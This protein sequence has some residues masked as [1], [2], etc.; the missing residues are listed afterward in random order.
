MS[1]L[2]RS[3]AVCAA[4][5]LCLP[6]PASAQVAYGTITDSAGRA[7][8]SAEV[9]FISPDGQTSVA[10]QRLRGST[11]F[12][13]SA[14]PP[15][16]RYISYS[17]AACAQ[18]YAS[19]VVTAPFGR[20]DSLDVAF[21]LGHTTSNTGGPLPD[22]A[23]AWRRDPKVNPDIKPGGTFASQ[24]ARTAASYYA[25][26]TNQPHDPAAAHDYL[27][28]VISTRDS[29]LRAA[30][31]GD[32]R[33]RA[34]YMM[35]G[36]LGSYTGADG[37][38]FA[39]DVRAALP[40]N[41]RWWTVQSGL[42]QFGVPILFGNPDAGDS[43]PGG[44]AAYM[45]MRAYLDSMTN[46]GEPSLRAEARGVL[47]T[48]AFA[49]GDSSHARLMLT[50]LLQD[51][52]DYAI[53]RLLASF[54]SSTRLDVGRR[55]PAFSFPSLPDTTGKPITNA[56]LTSKLTLIQFWGPRCGRCTDA[57]PSV[58][59]LYKKF[60][61]AG[62]QILSIAAD[63]APETINAFR[64]EQ[65]PMPWLNAIGGKPEA[66]RLQDLGIVIYPTFVLVDSTGTIVASDHDLSATTL[67]AVVGRLLAAPSAATRRQQER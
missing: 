55:M 61:P 22:G 34:A 18:G 19:Q 23:C 31:S 64:R 15:T 63:E 66:K 16:E 53:S 60:H 57:M 65:S 13:F 42:V 2:L 12:N 46:I 43:S 27:T 56:V 9:R 11:R 20:N 35:I 51:Q 54:Y 50:S 6:A 39:A 58:E 40:A 41:S 28:G 14:P 49:A 30:T 7:I 29:A 45:Q 33:E 17:I 3:G 5:W 26:T 47:I 10:V 4:L 48:N 32:E 21:T 59:A 25:F 37:A 67:D 8:P 1:L 62:L 38:R 44:R 52:P 24:A 36:P